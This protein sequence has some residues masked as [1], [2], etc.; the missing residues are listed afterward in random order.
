MI[1]G[2]RIRLRAPDRLDIPLFVTWLNDPEV[3]F[4]LLIHLP[5]SIAEEENWFEEMLKRPAHERPLV[6]EIMQGEEWLPIGNCGFHNIEWRVR[7]GEVGIMIGEKSFWNKGYGT[8]AIR[9]L[10]RHGF[11]TLNLNRIYLEVYENNP[12]AIR[13]YEKAGFIHEGRKRQAMFKDGEYLDI[14]IMSVLRQEWE[15]SHKGM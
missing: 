10:L 13:S 3:R 2:E 1:F 15:I 6:I 7:T 4:G 8:E 9:L 11:T 14:L 5:M 12:R